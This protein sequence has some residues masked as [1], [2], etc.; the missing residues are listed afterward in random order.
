MYNIKLLIVWLRLAHMRNLTMLEF[1]HRHIKRDRLF[2]Q[3]KIEKI[4]E[5]RKF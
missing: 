5:K 2:A 1:E 3:M 4:T